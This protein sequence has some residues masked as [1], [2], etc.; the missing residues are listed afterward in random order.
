M[1]TFPT[2]KLKEAFLQYYKERRDDTHIEV[3]RNSP[4]IQLYPEVRRVL[5]SLGDSQ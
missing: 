3:V 5:E 4:L 1:M 2:G